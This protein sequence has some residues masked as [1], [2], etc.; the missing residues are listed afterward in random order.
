MLWTGKQ[1]YSMIMNI[2]K[3]SN[4]LVNISTKCRNFDEAVKDIHGVPFNQI[5][6]HGGGKLD[7]S[8]CPADNYIVVYNGELL[9]GVADKLIVGEGSKNSI[10]YTALCDFGPEKCTGCMNSISR[11]SSRWISNRGFSIGIDDVQPN[12][13]L[14]E[15]KISI[16]KNGYNQCDDLIRSYHSDTL[17]A[18]PGCTAEE[19]LEVCLLSF[20]KKNIP[21]HLY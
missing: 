2:N 5:I 10:L 13:S 1:V 20:Q 21:S 7:Y 11:L 9:C 12:L 4:L 8:F 19:T 16:V 15:Q 18:S 6:T 17:T 14:N 3:S